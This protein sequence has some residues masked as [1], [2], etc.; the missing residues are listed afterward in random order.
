MSRTVRLVEQREHEDVWVVG[1]ERGVVTAN[2]MT[3]GRVAAVTLHS[4]RPVHGW[5]RS[6]RCARMEMPCWFMPSLTGTLLD[7]SVTAYRTAWGEEGLWRLMED[8]YR[9]YLGGTR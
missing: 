5:M 7:H 2:V 9:L 1:G 3:G 8:D 4:P 6:R